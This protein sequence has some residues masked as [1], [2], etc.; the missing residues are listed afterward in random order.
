LA[1]LIWV[2]IDEDR[3]E[4]QIGVPIDGDSVPSHVIVVAYSGGWQNTQWS[5]DDNWAHSAHKVKRT[6]PQIE[7]PADTQF[8]TTILWQILFASSYADGSI[9]L[10][11]PSRKDDNGQGIDQFYQV[12]YVSLKQAKINGIYKLGGVDV[13]ANGVGPLV[14]KVYPIRSANLPSASFPLTAEGRKIDL[15]GE[16]E[17]YHRNFEGRNASWFSISFSNSKQPGN[18]FELHSTSLWMALAWEN[19]P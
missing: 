17:V 1:S 6:T 9:Q 10:Q 3:K 8:S 16:T 12:P 4:V 13:V 19:R 18:W 11:D 7:D 15:H 14:S 2:K 5:F